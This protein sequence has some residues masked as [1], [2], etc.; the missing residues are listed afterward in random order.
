MARRI[1]KTLEQ[2]RD[3]HL[4]GIEL[5][6]ADQPERVHP[7]A[8]EHFVYYCRHGLCEIDHKRYGFAVEVEVEESDSVCNEHGEGTERGSDAENRRGADTSNQTGTGV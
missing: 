3:L 6:W 2:A 7:I 8:R 5:F 1:L 4:L